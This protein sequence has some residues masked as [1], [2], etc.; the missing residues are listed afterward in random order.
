MGAKP[1]E[2]RST[3]H[4]IHNLLHWFWPVSKHLQP[5]PFGPSP[6]FGFCAASVQLNFYSGTLFSIANIGVSFEPAL[7][8]EAD[9]VSFSS[10]STSWL[11]AVDARSV[12]GK[13]SDLIS[14]D[15][16]RV[17][18][19]N[20]PV[21]DVK[22]CAFHRGVGPCL[23]PPSGGH[24]HT[25]V[26]TETKVRAWSRGFA[27]HGGEEEATAQCGA[28]RRVFNAGGLLSVGTT[29]QLFP[30]FSLKIDKAP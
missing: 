6:I 18:T 14:L 16:R 9:R 24:S 12:A 11:E 2:T 20:G 3:S 17:F 1:K 4:V 8:R 27:A 25:A 21:L 28:Q 22:F 15:F 19:R 13:R 29:R 30:L 5:L 10:T 7:F 23:N 26:G